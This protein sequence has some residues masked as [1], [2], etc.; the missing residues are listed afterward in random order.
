[1]TGYVL[2]A[3][4]RYSNSG[5]MRMSYKVWR[6]L[7]CIYPTCISVKL[8]TARSTSLSLPPSTA[9]EHQPRPT[10][11]LSV[12]AISRRVPSTELRHHWLRRY[13]GRRTPTSQ[14]RT[15]ACRSYYE[16]CGYPDAPVNDPTS[17]L[18]SGAHV[19]HY[20]IL[21]CFSPCPCRRLEHCCAD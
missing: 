15:G 4:L 16:S 21:D 14:V 13:E 11:C 7:D 8:K 20:A 1:M 12:F 19:T 5:G 17:H 18:A 9:S 3:H 6:T 2:A 10:A